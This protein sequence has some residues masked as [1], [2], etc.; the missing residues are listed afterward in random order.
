MTFR[1]SQQEQGRR[2]G[3]YLWAGVVLGVLLSGL[4]ALLILFAGMP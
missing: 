4:L 1:A 2:L 3:R